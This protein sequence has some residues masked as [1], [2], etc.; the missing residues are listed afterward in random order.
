MK[1]STVPFNLNHLLDRCSL[2]MLAVDHELKILWKNEAFENLMGVRGS[3]QNGLS[4]TSLMKDLLTPADLHHLSDVLRNHSTVE[5]ESLLLHENHTWIKWEVS[6]NDTL[7]HSLIVLHDITEE[8]KTRRLTELSQKLS[9]QYLTHTNANDYFNDILTQLLEV[10]QSEY[11]FMGEVFY[12]DANPYLKTYAITNISWNKETSDFYNQYAPTGMEFRNL[13]TLFG[14]AMVTKQPM[15]ANQPATHPRKGG[16]PAGHPP[17]N[18]FL[19]IP[20]LLSNGDMVGLIG[21]A[22]RPGG[23][24]EQH[25]EELRLFLE[26]F[27]AIIQSKKNA[28][29]KRIMQTTLKDTLLEK[30]AI[31]KALNTSTLVS[32]SDLDGKL[33]NVNTLFCEATGYAAEELVGQ[34]HTLLSSGTHPKEFWTDL[35]STI[36]KGKSW[37]NEICNKH[38]NGNLF[39]VDTSINPIFDMEGNIIQF[40]SISNLI[41]QRKEFEKQLAH[42]K[43]Q[44][45]ASLRTKR[46]FLANISH[47]IR[48]PLHAILGVSEQIISS[49]PESGTKEQMTLVN[50]SANVL[51]NIINDV[52]DISRMEE[53]KMKLDRVSFDLKQV[54]ESIFK[55]LHAYASQKNLG[56]ELNFDPALNQIVSGDPVRLRQVLINIIGN[57]IKFTEKGNVRLTCKPVFSN[58]HKIQVSFL[59]ED[60]GVGISE[61]MKKRLFQ[62]FSQEDESFQR[63]FGGSGLGLAITNELVKMMEGTIQIDSEK[64]AGTQ[65][66][67]LLP[68]STQQVSEAPVIEK[69]TIDK[70]KLKKINVLI[71]EDNQFNRVLLQVIFNKN[72]INN[73]MAVNGVEAYNMCMSNDYDII[74]MDIQMPEMDG[75]EAM[76]KIRTDKSNRIPIIAV[77][78]NAIQEELN[79]YLEE[80]FND[81][82]TKPF[83]EEALLLKMLSFT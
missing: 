53:G 13:H 10:T 44:A 67:I 50:D 58:D 34:T 40:L 19:G 68:F 2:P 43:D 37:R 69:V 70:E 45:E 79:Y 52:I 15:I 14:H 6:Y 42:A 55:L 12:E 72:Q 35:W 30:D 57:A 46:R 47:E 11:G 29:E 16:T 62:D 1:E 3:N 18:A 73:D 51:L 49:L 7:C 41:T 64:N 9:E 4:L 17:L 39:W 21:L 22:N 48:T 8:I 63:K 20:V 38:K 66:H 24:H 25:V 61:E 56:F 33:L 77:T 27:G 81:F 75:L 26:L 32:V 78:A 71:A 5:Y 59:C 80:G 31:L 23:Y 74:L 54:I 65:V 36:S 83:T 60:T 82:I 28:E 76:R